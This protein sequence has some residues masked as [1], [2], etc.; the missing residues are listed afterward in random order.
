MFL[1]LCEDIE[2]RWQNNIAAGLL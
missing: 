2:D 1:Q